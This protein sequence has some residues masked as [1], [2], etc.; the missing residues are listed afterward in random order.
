VSVLRAGPTATGFVRH[1]DPEA[2]SEALELWQS[3]GRQA[4][5]VLPPE[6]V[7]ASIVHLLTRPAGAEVELLDLR[8]TTAP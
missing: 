8:P 5:A 7:A 6:A 4:G 1:F 3:M 2:F